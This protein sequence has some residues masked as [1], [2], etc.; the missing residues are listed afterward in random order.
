MNSVVNTERKA[1]YENTGAQEGIRTPTPDKGK[2]I[3]SPPRLPF[4]HLGRCIDLLFA[5]LDWYANQHRQAPHQYYTDTSETGSN[6]P[7]PRAVAI[8][9][10]APTL[11]QPACPG[12]NRQY[13]PVTLGILSAVSLRT[14]WGV[15][16]THTTLHATTMRGVSPTKSSEALGDG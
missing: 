12:T 13:R 9:P 6:S 8:F 1:S 15:D 16:A 14:L 4:R 7:G 5:R 3:L 2:R 11:Q 10:G